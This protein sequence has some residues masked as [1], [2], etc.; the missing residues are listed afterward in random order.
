MLL[1]LSTVSLSSDTFKTYW[2][3]VELLANVI[4]TELKKN[5]MIWKTGKYTTLTFDIRDPGVIG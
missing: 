1:I 2:D 5:F 3:M 4:A